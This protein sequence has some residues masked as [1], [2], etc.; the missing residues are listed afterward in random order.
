MAAPLSRFVD[1][2]RGEYVT[3]NRGACPWGLGDGPGLGEIAHV[4]IPIALSQLISVSRTMLIN[5][6]LQFKGLQL[7]KA[8]SRNI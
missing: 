7:R 6:Y 8:F 4:A 1:M 2:H 5:N 3:L